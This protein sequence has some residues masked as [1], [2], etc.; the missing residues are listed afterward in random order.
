MFVDVP[1][2]HPSVARPILQAMAPDSLRTSPRDRTREDV[3]QLIRASQA[4]TRPELVELTGLPASTIGHAVFKLL[5][6]GRIVESRPAAKGRG[7]GRGRPATELR[8]SATGGVNAGIDFGAGHVRIGIGDGLG[9]PIDETLIPVETTAL[10]EHSIEAALAELRLLQERHQVDHLQVLVAAI[11]APVEGTTGKV[12]A[13]TILPTWVG[14]SPTEELSRRLP[15]TVVQ[16]HNDALLGAF[17]ELRHG[18]GREHENFIYV[19]V[20]HGIGAGLVI[21]G[22]VYHGAA[23]LSGEIGHTQLPGHSEL[24]RCGNRGCLEAVINVDSIREQVSHTHPH[25]DPSQIALAIDEDPVIHRIL[26]EA[27]RTLGKALAVVC[28]LLNPTAVVLGGELGASG[29]ALAAGVRSSIQRFAQPATV[30]SI[31]V[32]PA[33]FGLRAELIGALAMASELV[34]RRKV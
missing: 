18:I 27:G 20:S 8:A 16:I 23:G 9:N 24:C 15:G 34:L 11:A 13:P 4:L 12:C 25:L 28:N 19:K 31:E 30:T 21:N 17:G 2:F 33:T 3:Y 29:S 7:S 5:A 10:P 22:E 14:L 32:R 26:A 1:S 6:E